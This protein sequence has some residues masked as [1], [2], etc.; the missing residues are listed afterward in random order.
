MGHGVVLSMVKR[1]EGG[2]HKAPQSEDQYQ[3][4]KQGHDHSSRDRPPILIAIAHP[5]MTSVISERRIHSQVIGIASCSG[6]RLSKA[7]AMCARCPQTAAGHVLA[8]PTFA[9]EKC[10]L[11]TSLVLYYIWGLAP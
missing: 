1:L 3:L 10:G 5:N 6:L 7:P 8:G 11:V 9:E 4:G 2:Q